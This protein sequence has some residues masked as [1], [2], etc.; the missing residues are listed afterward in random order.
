[1]EEKFSKDF[2][3]KFLFL[4]TNELIRNSVKK[5]IVQLQNI[6]EEKNIQQK[7]QIIELQIPKTEITEK[8]LVSPTYEREIISKKPLTIEPQ[9]IRRIQQ[10]TR[11]VQ[12]RPLFIP[13]P[14][15]PKH[16]EYLKPIK[17][18]VQIQFD[19]GKLNPLIKDR[20]VK[21]I[22]VNPEEK[23]RV[24]GSMGTK[25]TNIILTKEETEKIIDK[26]SEVSK[27]PR[28][29]GVYRVVGGDLML[30]AIISE[31]VGSRFIIKKIE[32]QPKPQQNPNPQIIPT[33]R[34]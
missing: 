25:P 11:L 6:I 33:K 32:E 9:P 10:V 13:E 3:K 29:E 15:L 12:R 2:R 21:I 7:K 24:I 34:Y 26:F 30:S 8:I 14:R 16:L 19:L 4:F 31:V 5:E 18:P 27:I 22:E 20:A 28:H 17:P 23:V 1:M